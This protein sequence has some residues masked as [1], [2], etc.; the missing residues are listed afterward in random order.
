MTPQS[1]PLAAVDSADRDVL[2]IGWST[3]DGAGQAHHAAVVEGRDPSATPSRPALPVVVELGRP[4]DP[5]V[6]RGPLEYRRPY[7]TDGRP[8][9][10][11]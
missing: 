5:R 9:R 3:D 7:A 10:T 2:V 1:P 6:E 11:R 8:P 4:S